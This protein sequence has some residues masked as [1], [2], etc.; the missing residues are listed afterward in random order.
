MPPYFH[1]YSIMVSLYGLLVKS[2]PLPSCCSFLELPWLFLVGYVRWSLEILQPFCSQRETSLSLKL[3]LWKREQRWDNTGSLMMLSLNQPTLILPLKFLFIWANKST[4]LLTNLSW[5]FNK[6]NQSFLTDNLVYL[7]LIIFQ[8][9]HYVW[10]ASY[11][12][13]L[14]G[15][16]KCSVSV[17]LLIG[18]IN[19][20]I[21][22]M[23][24]V[25]IWIYIYN[26]ISHFPCIISLPYPLPFSRFLWDWLGFLPSF[27]LIDLAVMH[28]ISGLLV[29][30]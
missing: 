30:S 4:L 18:K 9:Y 20:F 25:I 12:L 16:L 27:A 1:Y 14:S 21:I 6:F 28:S 19:P 29:F 15:Y 8:L 22:Y 2:C 7:F 10:C 11:K 13:Y 24:T 26:L 3:I 23:I 5:F 17:Y